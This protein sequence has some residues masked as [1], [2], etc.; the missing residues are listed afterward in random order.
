M[1]DYPS[2]R[3][4]ILLEVQVG[5][6]HF[7]IQPTVFTIHDHQP[8]TLSIDYQLDALITIYS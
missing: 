4:L 6:G 8:S 5:H 1:T 2:Q 7:T 3:M